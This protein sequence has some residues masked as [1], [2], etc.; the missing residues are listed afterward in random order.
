LEL[1]HLHQLLLKWYVGLVLNPILQVWKV[2]KRVRQANQ[3]EKET[4]H[5]HTQIGQHKHWSSH[6]SAIEQT[7]REAQ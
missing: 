3:E 2:G 1:A 6:S 5:L 7:A 4:G